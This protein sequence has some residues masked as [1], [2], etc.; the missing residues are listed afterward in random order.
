MQ[1]ASHTVIHG[2]ALLISVIFL[3]CA[4]VAKYIVEVSR[5]Q[6][7]VIGPGSYIYY[8][9]RHYGKYQVWSYNVVRYTFHLRPGL[10]LLL[11]IYPEVA[12]VLLALSYVAEMFLLFR[13]HL[14]LFASLSFAFCIIGIGVN[15]GYGA[16]VAAIDPAGL[17]AQPVAA[18]VKLLVVAMYSFSA[19]RKVRN[20]FMSGKVLEYGIRLSLSERKHP[21]HILGSSRLIGIRVPWLSS[22]LMALLVV[23]V[24]LLVGVL[25]L[26]PYPSVSLV[27]VCLAMISQVGFT[28]MFPRTLL[29]FTIAAFSALV[30]WL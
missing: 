20:G 9:R 21:D 4:V 17:Y 11:L 23:V 1:L 12:G 28:T 16:F 27:G 8:A 3:V 19:I 25:M 10:A 14:V 5:G 6:L 18:F 15:G 26:M 2:Y 30:L 7:K 22:K 13:Y 29:P 24:E